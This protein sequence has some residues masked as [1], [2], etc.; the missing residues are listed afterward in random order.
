VVETCE[1][2]R[3]AKGKRGTE[4][5]MGGDEGDVQGK[6]IEQKCVEM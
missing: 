2:E 6:E 5:G 1:E 4:L 3:R